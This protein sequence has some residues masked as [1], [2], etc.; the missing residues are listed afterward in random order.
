MEVGNTFVIT[1]THPNLGNSVVSLE[2]GATSTGGKIGYL[3]SG[4]PTVLTDFTTSV[5]VVRVTNDGPVW[6]TGTTTSA[7]AEGEQENDPFELQVYPNP[8]SVMVNISFN[9]S[10]RATILILSIYKSDGQFVKSFTQKDVD[11]GIKKLNW[12][13]QDAGEGVYFLKLQTEYGNVSKRVMVIK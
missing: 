2:K 1:I 8:A 3:S 5:H 12:N 4:I 11:K 7:I 6:A 9:L 13:T 10:K